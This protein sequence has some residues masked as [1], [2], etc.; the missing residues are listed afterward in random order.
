ML[1]ILIMSGWK[2]FFKVLQHIT[3]GIILRTFDSYGDINFALQAFTTENYLIGCLILAP[4]LI[5]LGFTFHIWKSSS[6]DSAKAKRWSWILVL[7]NFWPQYQVVKL[8]KAIISRNPE[9]NWENMENKLDHQ[10]LF[11]EPWLEAI[12]QFFS[13]VSVFF[14]LYGRDTSFLHSQNSVSSR[15][16]ASDT[17][18]GN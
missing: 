4:V 7:L 6:F 9:K 16:N 1:I 14:L 13:S 3:F 12:P 10:L 5:S 8:I 2:I 17:D 18:I 11:I 15:N